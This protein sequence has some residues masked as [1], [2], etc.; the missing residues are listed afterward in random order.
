MSGT[1][2]ART[3]GLLAGVALTLG[4]V[5][6]VSPPITPVQA[7]QAPVQVRLG[8]IGGAS[9]AGFFIGLDQGY[10]REQGIELETTQFD[11]A[12]RMVAPLG[13]GQL[14][15]GGGAHSAGLMNAIARGIALKI[16]ADKGSTPP[17]FGFQALLFRGDL[18]DSGAL[19]RPADL[20]GRRVAVSAQGTSAEVSLGQWLATAGLT[21]DDVDRVELGFPDHATALGGGSVDASVTIEPFL[22]RILDQ[23]TARIY[24]RTDEFTPGR[25]VAEVLYGGEFVQ[26]QPDVA[27]RFMVAYLRALRDYNDA[28]ARGDTAK[29]ERV[30]DTL[31]HHTPVRDRALYDRMVMPGLDPNGRV[32]RASIADDQEF[33]LSRGTAHQRVN[34][35][36]VIDYSFAD[37]AVRALGPY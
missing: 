28:F 7:A 26:E 37:A 20:R 29:Q 19:R 3:A 11:S 32:D 4:L 33:W 14:D 1:R 10:F 9:D 5:A 34:L 23:G 15:A 12:A 18:V 35:D 25:Q 6:H 2:A 13:A 24:Q 30:I 36:T 31:I 8:I 21:L 16:V 17:G 27:R 22:T